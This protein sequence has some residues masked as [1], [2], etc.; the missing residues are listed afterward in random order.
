MAADTLVALSPSD[1]PATQAGLAEWCGQKIAALE[2][3]ASELDEHRMIAAANGWKLSAVTAALNRTARRITYYDK[4]RQA[5]EAGFLIVPN[6]P[7]TVLAVRVDRRSSRAKGHRSYASNFSVAP[8]LLPAGVGRYV[9]AEVGSVDMSYDQTDGKG[10]TMTVR[11]FEPIDEM[12][13]PDFPMTAV[14]PT[15]MAATARAMALKVFDEIGLVQNT[16][17]GDPILVGRLRDPRGSGRLCTFFLA[18][19]LDP[20]TL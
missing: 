2:R 13:A 16:A 18:W 15:V 9:D 4:M 20:E 5:V 14:K 17:P 10:G 12:D 11:R 8:Q 6:F 19:W 3:E 7:V 1:L